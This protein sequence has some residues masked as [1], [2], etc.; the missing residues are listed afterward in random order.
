MGAD[1]YTLLGITKSADQESVK[2]SWRRLAREYHPDRNPSNKPEAEEKFKQI[3]EA[4]N[5]L[6]N[7]FKRKLYDG[8]DGLNPIPDPHF[9]PSCTSSTSPKES[10][11][12]FSSFSIGGSRD[13]N[14][15]P[16]YYHKC[17]FSLE[18]LYTGT[19]KIVKTPNRVYNDIPILFNL[20]C[21]FPDIQFQEEVFTIDVKP[22]YKDGTKITFPNKGI[23][24]DG[25]NRG[26][27]VVL[28]VQKTHDVYQRV[29]NDLVIT[30]KI[31]LLEALTGKTLYVRTLDGRHLKVPVED[32][33]RPG[34]EVVVPDEGM[35]I[36]KEPG[37]KGNLRIKFDV[38]YPGSLSGEQKS[39]LTR[40]LRRNKN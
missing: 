1:Y 24:V 6:G 11:F 23:I 37:K 25:Y 39:D 21:S 36:T 15:A 40:V 9:P 38:E 35:P 28:V 7:P 30:Q 4:Y 14:K 31:D 8:V 33:V 32:I 10:P 2:K 20:Y 13:R 29:W 26:D 3:S 18:E 22:G 16:P 12:N 34:Y 17:Y 19:T 5:V 27:F